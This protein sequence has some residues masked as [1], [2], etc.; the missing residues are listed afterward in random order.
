MTNHRLSKDQHDKLVA[1]RRAIRDSMRCRG[2]YVEVVAREAI[3][4]HPQAMTFQRALE[5]YGELGICAAGG[6]EPE[7]TVSN[8]PYLAFMR[9][10][11]RWDSDT[12]VLGL[13]AS[14]ASLPDLRGRISRSMREYFVSNDLADHFVTSLVLPAELDEVAS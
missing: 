4:D 5:T 1:K 6:M 14:C 12:F 3:G 11:P 13:C 9:R 8:A 10:H 2:V 7:T